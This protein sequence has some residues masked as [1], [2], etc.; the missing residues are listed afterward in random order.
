MFKNDT[1]SDSNFLSS[2]MEGGAPEHIIGS[3][4]NM[5]N[6]Q[7]KKDRKNELKELILKES[8]SARTANKTKTQMLKRSLEKYTL[9]LADLEL[10]LE[11]FNSSPAARTQ[12]AARTHVAD[13]ADRTPPAAAPA[14]TPLPQT[15]APTTNMP[16]TGPPPLAAPPPPPPPPAAPAATP[17]P[18]TVAPSTN[19]PYT[20]STLPVL[21]LSDSYKI[22]HQLMYTGALELAAYGECRS[23]H[24]LLKDDPRL[25]CFGL[26]YIIENYIDKELTLAQINKVEGF[27]KTHG[28]GGQPFPTNKDLFENLKKCN[29]IPIKIYGLKEGTVI[30][31]H[32]PVYMIVA[33]DPNFLAMVTFFETILTMVWYPISVATLSRGCRDIFEKAYDDIGANDYKPFAGAQL[34]D[35][36][37]RGSTSIESSIIGGMAHLLNSDGSDTMSASFYA[38]YVCNQGNPIV[39]TVAASEHSVMTSFQK[40]VD[41]MVNLLVKF[42]GDVADGKTIDKDGYNLLKG[43]MKSPISIVMDSYNYE[44]SLLKI[45]PAAVKKFILLRKNAA[46]SKLILQ[47]DIYENTNKE[48]A[49]LFNLFKIND[50][51]EP[52]ISYEEQRYLPKGFSVVFRPDSGN[53]TLAVLQGLVAGV[54]LFG[55]ENYTNMDANMRFLYTKPHAHNDKIYI[56]PRYIRVLQADGININTIRDIIAAVV[57][58]KCIGSV[59]YAFNPTSLLFGMGGGLLQKVERG[60]TDFA[61]KLCYVKYSNGVVKKV[62]K[63][64]S[65]DPKKRS[66]P[67]KLYVQNR[68]EL[69]LVRPWISKEEAET[70]SITSGI[71]VAEDIKA[72]SSPDYGELNLLYDGKGNGLYEKEES[73][74]YTYNTFSKLK[75]E[76]EKKWHAVGNAIKMDKF[77]K[78][79]VDARTTRMQDEQ[80]ITA[81]TATVD[82]K[83][84]D[85]LNLIKNVLEQAGLNP[86]PSYFDKDKDISFSKLFKSFTFNKKINDLKLKDLSKDYTYTQFAKDMM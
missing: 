54:H 41:A 61:T 58:P 14:A 49:E 22:S 73:R 48:I 50:K 83:K 78:Y 62:M 28:L 72:D 25:I 11:S 40:E 60:T 65:T 43:D 70:A 85:H 23:A 20:V 1:L 16:Y 79:C 63:D 47:Q 75:Q 64:P 80:E 17:L 37:F 51:Y 30:L 38:Q 5:G 12:V 26:K 46:F 31:P 56:K 71:K 6:I 18:Q 53:P 24:K 4:I 15:M 27:Y 67:G 44:N 29:K 8:R 84:I 74:Q 81:D 7:A 57:D 3:P 36:G 68:E 45:F 33:D 66:L 10:Q 21:I 69:L 35:F 39:G 86:L 76:V 2:D 13:R 32:T 42:G 19:M 52:L 55:I 9:E 82:A 34:L 59:K 77:K